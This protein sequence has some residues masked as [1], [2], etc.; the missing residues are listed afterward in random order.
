MP[1]HWHLLLWPRQDGEL[2]AFLR[3][4]TVTHTKRWHTHFGTTATGPLYQGRFKS[5]PVQSNRHFIAVARYIERNSLRACLVSSADKWIWSSLAFRANSEL[6]NLIP[7]CAWP[8]KRPSNWLDKVNQP[9]PAEELKC[10]RRSVSKGCPYG[11]TKWQEE[12]AKALNIDSNLR[13]PGRPQK[14]RIHNS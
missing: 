2:S 6:L 13:S 3:L 12:T 9:Q 1:N 14:P 5:F 8:V 11:D 10:L 7:L 4:V